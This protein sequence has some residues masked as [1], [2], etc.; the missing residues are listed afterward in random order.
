MWDSETIVGNFYYSCAKIMKLS[1][2][3]GV[4][5][6]VAYDNIGEVGVK[7]L[8]IL[9]SKSI[10]PVW[11]EEFSKFAEF[12]VMNESRMRIKNELVAIKNRIQ[13]WFA[14]GKINLPYKCFLGY[15]KGEDGFP[16]VVDSEAR[17]V[18]RIYDMFYFKGK[19]S[20][21]I[22]NY[23]TQQ[24]IPTPA[25]KTVWQCNR[26]VKNNEKC[27]TPHL[28]EDTIKNAFVQTF[29]STIENREEIIDTILNVIETIS[30]TSK[31]DKKILDIQAKQKDAAEYISQWV[32]E[33]ASIRLGIQIQN[34]AE[35][36]GNVITNL[37]TRQSALPLTLLKNN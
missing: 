15:E 4:F 30:D 32:H 18:R 10:V 24:K 14:D 26:K 7:R 37:R 16:K 31:L 11:E 20:S 19:T 8:L 29:N 27:L 12:R 28:T 13:R 22:A 23:L 35:Q 9:A 6:W 2:A 5:T 3:L 34:T 17:I 33:N 25:G 36:Y 1:Y 21:N